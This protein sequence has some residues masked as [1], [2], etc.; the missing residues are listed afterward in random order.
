MALTRPK[1]V[2]RKG[3]NRNAGGGGTPAGNK[4]TD[5]T[6][7]PN[8]PT[9]G[10]TRRNGVSPGTPDAQ[11]CDVAESGDF[12]VVDLH[13]NGSDATT[14]TALRMT[15]NTKQGVFLIRDQPI[16][17]W[18]A[19]GLARPTGH[20]FPRTHPEG[21]LIKLEVLFDT[22][23]IQGP[24]SSPSD[25]GY[26][27]VIQVDAGVCVYDADQSGSPAIPA[28]NRNLAGSL[29]KV[30]GN[31]ATGGSSR[32]YKAGYNNYT[33]VSHVNTM[34]KS[35]T[36]YEVTGNDTLVW[37]CGLQLP[38]RPALTNYLMSGAISY[39][40]PFG[41]ASMASY[42]QSSSSD[43]F[44]DSKYLHFYLGFGTFNNAATAGQVRIKTI[45]YCIQ[46]LIGRIPFE[47]A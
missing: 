27:N 23:P 14:S 7:L 12:L 6:V 34:W 44:L 31:P 38:K 10:W 41:D 13:G 29:M 32:V 9:D 8:D 4:W 16:D 30:T 19:S 46:P 22:I 36:G 47:D 2:D 1:R 21:F 28:N 15:G 18:A 33:G 11:Y 17:V 24:A 5:W 35:Q 37:Y 26:G 39:G 40:T 3:S 25:N 42:T 45:R 43:A 20:S